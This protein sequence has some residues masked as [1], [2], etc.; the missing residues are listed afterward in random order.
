VA[1]KEVVLPFNKFPGADTLLGPEMRST[2]EVMGIDY[3]FASSYAKAQIA[4]GQKLPMS[5]MYGN[6]MLRRSLSSCYAGLY[7]ERAA[8]GQIFP[9]SGGCVLLLGFAG[10]LMLIGRGDGIDYDFASSYAK[11]QIAAGQKLLMSGMYGNG[12]RCCDGVRMMWFCYGVVLRKDVPAATQ[13]RRSLHDKSCPCQVCGLLWFWL[14][15]L[16]PEMLSPGEVVASLLLM[17]VHAH[18]AAAAAGVHLHG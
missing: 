14:L 2:G 1:V 12:M 5:G 11:A 15:L 17:L 18:A 8:A 4:A 7:A 13:R 6:S 9:M 3:D 10:V 16:G